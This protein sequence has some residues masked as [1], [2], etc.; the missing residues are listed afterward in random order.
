MVLFLGCFGGDCH[1]AAG[2][3][4]FVMVVAIVASYGTVIIKPATAVS[5]PKWM[6]LMM[7]IGY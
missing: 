1:F 4:V 2:V 3:F 6:E 7:L 5:F